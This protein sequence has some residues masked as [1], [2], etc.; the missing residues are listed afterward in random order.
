MNQNG[1]IYNQFSSNHLAVL[2]LVVFYFDYLSQLPKGL[3]Y[4]DTC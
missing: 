3:C 1:Q 4:S 2:F